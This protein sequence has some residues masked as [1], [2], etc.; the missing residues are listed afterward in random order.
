MKN[1]LILTSVYPENDRD[2]NVTHV[3]HYFAKELVGRYNVRVVHNSVYYPVIV[4]SILKLFE[5]KLTRYINYF[6]LPKY[7]SKNI[8]TYKKD[9]VLVN[10]IPILKKW[11]S[12]T[13]SLKA[14]NSQL[15][16]IINILKDDDF[17]PDY[18]IGHWP[19]PQLYLVYRISKL[20]GSKSC[21]VLHNNVD[22][23]PR[24]KHENINDIIKSI[25]VWGYRSPGIKEKF[26]RLY[27]DTNNMFHCYSGV[28][29]DEILNEG[30]KFNNDVFNVVFVG[31]LIKRKYPATILYALKNAFPDKKFT[32]TY[33]GTGPEK[34]NIYKTAKK[35][36]IGDNITFIENIERKEVFKYLAAS[37]CF[38]MISKPE[39]FGL[40][41]LEAMAKGC[42]TIGSKGEGIDGIIVDEY[43]G[44]L[45]EA[46]NE[47]ELATIFQRICK[48][49][50]ENLREISQ[51]AIKVARE[52]S[53]SKAA[54]NYIESIINI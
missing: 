54:F 48:M 50:V 34:I 32:I 26:K 12:S 52:Y 9:G 13:I 21:I 27:E 49:P 40:V 53:D 28:P 41:Y 8:Y 36:S 31:Q 39:T 30:K 38:V 42:L 14:L 45:C 7:Q 46:G 25:D 17:V 35:L 43:N 51:N 6:Y 37:D 16:K 18:I 5:K 24:L 3:V 11:P 1:V 2:K 33:I 19:E 44:F 22:K 4:Y 10:K 47:H 15:N 23:I 20:Y 29:D